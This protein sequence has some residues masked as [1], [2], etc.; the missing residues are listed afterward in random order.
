MKSNTVLIAVLSGFLFILPGCS[1]K[2]A[3]SPVKAPPESQTAKQSSPEVLADLAKYTAAVNQAMKPWGTVDKLTDD[4]KKAK[5]AKA[6][7]AKL[8]NEF[9]PLV[10]GVVTQ[11]EAIKPVTTEV[12]TIHAAFLASIKNYLDGLQ[13][14]AAGVEKN[15]DAAVNAA[16]VK[17]NAFG[18]AHAKFVADTGALANQ[19][20]VP[21]K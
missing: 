2:Q 4:L 3:Q 6:Y 20:G 9:A 14:M 1:D 21:T 15:D 11:M 7:A 5:N 12:Q 17:L 10:S 19:T 16:A 13:S 8:R 18:P